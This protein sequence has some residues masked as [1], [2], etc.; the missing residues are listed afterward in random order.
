MRVLS[1]ARI[2]PEGTRASREP[3]LIHPPTYTVPGR[4]R[5]G[6]ISELPRETVWKILYSR[7]GPCYRVAVAHPVPDR[8]QC[9]LSSAYKP[10]HA[11]IE[12]PHSLAL[13]KAR[14]LLWHE[15]PLSTLL[16]VKRYVV[17]YR[18]RELTLIALLS[19]LTTD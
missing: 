4:R 19:F 9:V 7:S 12:S 11:I 6:L 16:V 14:L 13:H 2:I 10:V 8:P 5:A 15:L 18:A 3:A 17:L 1:F